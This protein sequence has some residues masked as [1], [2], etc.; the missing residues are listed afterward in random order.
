MSKLH[1]NRIEVG[2]I[3]TSG[4]NSLSNVDGHFIY[5]STTNLLEYYNPNEINT[6]RDFTHKIVFIFLF[7]IYPG[8]TQILFEVF[9]CTEVEGIFYLN[10]DLRY[11]CARDMLRWFISFD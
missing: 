2:N 5:N 1:N 11:K 3:S 6:Y 9:I 10:K 8:I 7:I 4:R